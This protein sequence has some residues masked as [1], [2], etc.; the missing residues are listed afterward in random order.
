MN[1]PWKVVLAFAVV[2]LAGG[3]AGGLVA[4]RMAPTVVQ[5]RVFSEQF[6]ASQMRRLVEV[7][8]LS[9]E[10][11]EKIR[12]IV[13]AT[14][15]ELIRLRRNTSAIFERMHAGI[16]RELNPEQRARHEA[17]LIKMS[18]REQRDRERSRQLEEERSKAPSDRKPPEGRP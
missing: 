14:G 16:L 11:V 2:F 10:Q 5:R 18:E 15:E 17:W 8:Q 9:A 12:P 1:K 13:E 3:V 6:A 4:V 7:H